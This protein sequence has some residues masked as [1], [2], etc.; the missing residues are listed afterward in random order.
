MLGTTSNS[1][2]QADE[3]QLPLTGQPSKVLPMLIQIL[4]SWVPR[5]DIK[6]FYIGRSVDPGNLVNAQGCDAYGI[7]YDAGSIENAMTVEDSL[8]L[9]FS[10]DP[11]YFNEAMRSD[12]WSSEGEGNSVY[13]AF[14]R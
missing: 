14:W 9:L 5:A 8:I 13:V 3:M 6:K 4:S 2:G 11:K 12:G 7:L 10:R 1:A